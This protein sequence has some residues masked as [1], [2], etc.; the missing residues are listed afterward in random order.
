MGTAPHAMISAQGEQALVT[1]ALAI[2]ELAMFGEPR[3]R[4]FA[5]EFINFEEFQAQAEVAEEKT[6]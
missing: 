4:T 2:P 1:A 5:K 3:L 6:T